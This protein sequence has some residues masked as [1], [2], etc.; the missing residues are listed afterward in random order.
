[1]RY[2][3]D[4]AAEARIVTADEL[5][6]LVAPGPTLPEHS[7]FEFPRWIWAVMLG[8]YGTFLAGL[9]G[10][11]AGGGRAEFAIAISA[12]YIAMFFGT[13]CV[14]ANVDGRRIGSFDRR[15]GIL[16]T[17]TGPMDMRSVVGQVLVLPVLLG[18]FGVSIAVISAVVM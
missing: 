1:M 14:M 5:A 7:D 10:A 8:G 15:G 18:F 3:Q 17:C 12:F 4:F 16:N 6:R 11:T 2:I 9:L 13:G